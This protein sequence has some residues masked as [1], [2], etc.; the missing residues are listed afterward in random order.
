MNI[1]RNEGKG[2]MTD[3][4]QELLDQE[5]AEECPACGCISAYSWDDVNYAPR[6]GVEEEDVP[7]SARV[8]HI[9]AASGFEWTCGND[10]CGL[11]WTPWDSPLAAVCFTHAGE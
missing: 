6:A 4:Q 7:V 11:S 3:I 5:Y 9:G 2:I 1:R 8:Y 10:H